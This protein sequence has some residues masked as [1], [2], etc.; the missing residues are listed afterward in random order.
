MN[1]RIDFAKLSGSGNDFICIDGRDERYASL[2]ADPKA[3]GHFARTLCRRGL[4]VGAD[5]VIFACNHEVGDYADVAARFLEADGSEAELCGNGTACFV[6]WIIDNRWF[7]DAQSIR[8]LTGAG[9]VRGSDSQDNYVKVCIP[10]PEQAARDLPLDLEDQRLAYDYAV[11]GVPHAVIYVDDVTAVDMPH[12][13]PAIRHHQ[14]FQP[15]GVN[16]NFVESQGP[17]RIAVRTFEFGVE[18]ET[19]ACGTGSATAACF[20]ARRFN[21]PEEFLKGREPILVSVRS[22]DIMKVWV[23]LDENDM[24]C[25]LCL[26]TVVREV[27]H[28]TLEPA[29]TRLAMS[30]G[31]VQ[32]A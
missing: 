19:Y 3:I 15:R 10:F 32:T 11:T 27:Y 9:V 1:T 21:W 8:I 17:G 20:A 26:E 12:L 28:G 23:T 14:Q 18:A 6:R 4:G 30:A 24:I 16:V 13:G 25:D 5:G 31:P 29:M 2:L 7:P 22:G